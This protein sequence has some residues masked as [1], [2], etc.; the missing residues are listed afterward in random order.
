MPQRVFPD[1]L[2]RE[3]LFLGSV[4]GLVLTSIYRGRIPSYSIGDAE[5]VFVLGTL[6]IAV[7]GLERSG[8]LAWLSAR[9]EKGRFLALKLVATTFFLSMLVTNDVALVALV[10]LTLALDVRRRDL[11][12]ILEALAA[13]AG[14]ALTPFGNP[15]NLFIYWFY[16]LDPAEFIATIAPFSLLFLV[17]FVLFALWIR[18][19]AVA[20]SSRSPV[21]A[22]RRALVYGGLLL[23]VI[24]TVLRLLPVETGLVVLVYALLFDRG[25]LRID[26]ALLFTLVCFFGITDNLKSLLEASLAHSGHIFLFSAL[27]SQ[28]ISNV[29]AALLFA[30]FTDQW[31]ALL[32]GTS[33]G[34]FGGLLGS[35]ANLIAYK[36]YTA[37]ES[38]GD[39]AAFTA[40]FMLFSYVAFF[41]GIAQFF[42]LAALA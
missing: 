16:G 30:D 1:F 14:S 7:K 4:A 8:L 17:L 12:V 40:K 3:W 19:P 37:S 15:Q 13:N 38:T 20:V 36:L 28:L 5:V 11:L 41:I 29:P 18:V 32:W 34:G 6:F 21:L 39:S 27:S 42:L 31:R 9:I 33:V 26:Y 24:L 23:T 35:L 10:P 22:G 2:L 25:S